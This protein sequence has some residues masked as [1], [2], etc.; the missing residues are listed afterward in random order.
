MSDIKAFTPT[1]DTLC[2]DI[3]TEKPVQFPEAGFQ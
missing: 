2:V 1:F 3:T